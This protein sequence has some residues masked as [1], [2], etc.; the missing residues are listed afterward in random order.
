MISCFLL[1]VMIFTL[2][3]VPAYAVTQGEIDELR[4]KRAQ[5]EQEHDE[6]QEIVDQLEEEKA[7]VLEKKL[8]MDERNELT[9]QEIENLSDEIQLLDQAIVEKAIEV[10]VA[11]ADEEKQLERYR[12]RIRA[13]EENG[14][15]QYLGL[16]LQV[17][18]L[19]DLLTAVIDAGDIIKS[20]QELYDNFI[21]AREHTQ[22]VKAEFEAEKEQLQAQQEDLRKQQRELQK[23]IDEAIRMIEELD[24]DIDRKNK[25]LEELEKSEPET[26][27]LIEKLER[28]R[29][30]EARRRREEEAR[31][32]QAA[33]NQPSGGGGGGS[34]GGG[35][36]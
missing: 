32:Q 25:E 12:R 4:K 11:R 9:R 21:A 7:S 10:E 20:D 35:G 33:A 16:I 3:P 5:I 24:E 14:D 30:E 23:E 36:S 15:M 18:N 13:M 6:K 31:R 28:Q 22:E 27:A 1:L 2:L 26:A 17:D 34:S 19:S 8:A 29:E